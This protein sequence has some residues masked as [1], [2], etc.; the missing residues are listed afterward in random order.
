MDGR[1]FRAVS[2]SMT[3]RAPPFGP[4]EPD[5]S[6]I[7]MDLLAPKAPDLAQAHQREPRQL[8]HHRRRE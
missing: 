4:W 6:L 3:A 8:R 7:E 5:D 2:L 1:S